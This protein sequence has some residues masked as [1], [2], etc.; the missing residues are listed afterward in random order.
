MF[1]KMLVEVD[2]DVEGM[3]RISYA[4]LLYGMVVHF[5]IDA[6]C[7]QYFVWHKNGLYDTNMFGMTQKTIIYY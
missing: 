3:I 1:G 4:S 2:I 6:W 5:G 7:S